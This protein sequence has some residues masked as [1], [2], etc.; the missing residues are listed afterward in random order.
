MTKFR[1]RL[2]RSADATSP[3]GE[4]RPKR[5]ARGRT[6]ARV[7]HRRG[8]DSRGR[9]S[10]PQRWRSDPALTVLVRVTCRGREPESQRPCWSQAAASQVRSRSSEPPPRTPA[11]PANQ[12]L[13]LERDRRPSEVARR[14]RTPRGPAVSSIV[15]SCRTTPYLRRWRCRV[16]LEAHDPLHQPRDRRRFHE[17]GNCAPAA[18]GFAAVDEQPGVLSPVGV[19]DRV[20]VERAE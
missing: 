13:D 14:T 18:L 8:S 10:A 19:D 2:T 5:H 7:V 3:G 20:W 6:S 9:R 15:R 16:E 4:S 12:H 17:A 1:H 11:V